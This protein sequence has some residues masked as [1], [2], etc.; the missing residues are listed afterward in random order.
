M[1]S[2]QRLIAAISCVLA[3]SAHGAAGYGQDIGLNT[4]DSTPVYAA[5]ATQ[6]NLSVLADYLPAS[7]EEHE[8]ELYANQPAFDLRDDTYS[9][10]RHSSGLLA[11]IW[12]DQLNFYSSESLLLIGV[13][14]GAGA[15]IANT[16]LDGDIQRHLQSSLHHANS[17][18][19][20]E[21]LHANKELGDGRYTLPIFASAWAL[22]SILPPSQF[23]DGSR[24][25]G[26]RTIRGF[27]V[28]APPVLLL[29]RVTGSS[30]PGETANGSEWEPF[31]DNNGVSGHAFM[32]SL[33]F[34]TAAKM[35]DSLAWK[36]TFYAASALAPLS[37]TADG[38]HYPSQVA[39]GWSMAFIAATAVHS[40]DNPNSRWHIMS[41]ATPNG[42]GMALEYR[43]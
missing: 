35:S 9:S 6:P 3:M 28:G 15:A 29:Q 42:S 1:N 27:L 18:E 41:T 22:G 5:E 37:R 20:L 23:S 16:Q 2:R 4:V 36:T 43:F 24:I 26:Q 30:R 12:N 39:L 21:G 33:P 32:G 34:I 25:W 17:D 14:L 40:T 11:S 38:A 31:R 7:G 19:W 8:L 13:S 10:R